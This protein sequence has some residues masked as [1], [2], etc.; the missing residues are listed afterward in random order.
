MRP[1]AAAGTM[2]GAR[3]GCRGRRLART[4]CLFGGRGVDSREVGFLRRPLYFPDGVASLRAGDGVRLLRRSALTRVRCP[5]CAERTPSPPAARAAAVG[6]IPSE[7][8]PDSFSQRR[9]PRATNLRGTAGRTFLHD[10]RSEG[11][12]WLVLVVGVERG[13]I[14]VGGRLGSGHRRTIAVPGVFLERLRAPPTPPATRLTA[15]RP[16]PRD[17]FRDAF[18]R[19]VVR[20]P[21][22]A[23]PTGWARRHF[24]PPRKTPPRSACAV[25]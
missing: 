18:P 22:H 21:E 16:E 12:V 10:D 4:V 11:S 2:A 7:R 1:A 8:F 14:N 9:R 24:R 6:P 19:P 23:R 25:S 20:A 15:I 13:E 5:G 3:G 17:V